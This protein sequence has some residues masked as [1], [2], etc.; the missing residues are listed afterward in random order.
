MRHDAPGS[1]WNTILTINQHQLKTPIKPDYQIFRWIFSLF[2]DFF[3]HL[4][5]MPIKVVSKY[6]ISEIQQEIHQENY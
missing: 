6:L 4:S 3:I 1:S 2:L 5:S